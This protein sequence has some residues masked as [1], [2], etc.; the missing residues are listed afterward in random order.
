MRQAAEDHR[1]AAL[2]IKD[3]VGLTLQAANARAASEGR[4]ISD[5]SQQA[6]M[7]MEFCGSR[8]RVWLDATGRIEKAEAG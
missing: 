3:Y 1:L 6:W 2:P 5:E 8:V 7:T 4:F